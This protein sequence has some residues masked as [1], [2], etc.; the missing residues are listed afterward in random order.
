MNPQRRRF[1]LLAAALL[2]PAPRVAALEPM[3]EVDYRLIQQRPVADPKQVEVVE[4][5]YYGCR[6]CNA[7]EPYLAE[8]RHRKPQDV[9]FRLQPAIRNTRWITLTKLFYVLEAEGQ[10]AR[11]HERVYQAYHRDE[12]NLADESVLVAWLVEQGLERDRV[13][14]LLSSDAIMAKVHEARE[15]TY[16][17]EVD[18]T[19]SIV[20]AGRYLTTSGMAGCVSVR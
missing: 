19:P 14:K 20:V 13:E 8:W 11:L 7:F 18:T 10:L 5:F 15:T 17:Y 2:L 12:R 4:F 6:W 1:G 9:A 3:E 16:D